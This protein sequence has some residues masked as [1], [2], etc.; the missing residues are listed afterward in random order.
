ME[1]K[2][3]SNDELSKLFKIRKTV[4]KMLEDRG[5]IVTSRE[6]NEKF[7]DWTKNFSPDSLPILT[8]KASDLSEFIFVEFSD[9][10]KLGVSEIKSF[11]DRLEKQNVRNGILIS[12]GTISSL[13]RQVNLFLKI[14]KWQNKIKFIWSIL[15]KRN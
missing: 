3:I 7:E 1:N 8:N 11:S 15:K 4:L 5:Y 2:Q 14:S 12:S 13:A 9:K 10:E 6:L